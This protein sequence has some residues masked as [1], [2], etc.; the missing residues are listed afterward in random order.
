MKIFF[1]KYVP[2]SSLKQDF[3][4]EII[5]ESFIEKVAR[6]TTFFDENN[7][8]KVAYE[9]LDSEN[10]AYIH[11]NSYLSSTMP[12]FLIYTEMFVAKKFNFSII[13]IK[14]LF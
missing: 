7:K 2:P 11:P 1:K 12:E 6:K 14:K 5:I 4:I 8:K 3:L 9:V 10:R 13:F